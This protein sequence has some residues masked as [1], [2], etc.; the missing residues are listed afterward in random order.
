MIE[1]KYKIGLHLVL[2]NGTV[3]DCHMA[4]PNKEYTSEEIDALATQMRTRIGQ[5]DNMETRV[6]RVWTVPQ[7]PAWRSVDE[8]II[9]WG[10]VK[11][12]SYMKIVRYS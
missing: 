9:L 12:N 5:S 2:P 6:T 3:Y 1:R 7:A 8:I 11:E 10:A 4:E